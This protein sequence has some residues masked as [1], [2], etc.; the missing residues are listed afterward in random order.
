MKY[1][2]NFCNVFHK[3]KICKNNKITTRKVK[4]KNY[5]PWS[6]RYNK[7]ESILKIVS[8]SKLTHSLNQLSIFNK[9]HS[10]QIRNYPLL[11]SIPQSHNPSNPVKTAPCFLSPTHNKVYPLQPILQLPIPSVSDSPHQKIATKKTSPS[12]N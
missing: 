9:I 12:T 6:R 8:N 4:S 3:Q 7:K 11:I 5:Q 1:N 10:M 2:S